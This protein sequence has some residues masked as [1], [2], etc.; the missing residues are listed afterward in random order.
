MT[1][2]LVKMTALASEPGVVVV[3]EVPVVLVCDVSVVLVCDVSVGVDVEVVLC[4][5]SPAADPDPLV[6]VA[7]CEPVV[8]VASAAAAY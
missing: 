2:G 3:V 7:G 5:Q 6:V 1:K 8:V 4:D